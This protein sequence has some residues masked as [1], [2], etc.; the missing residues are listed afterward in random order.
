M[1]E[2]II[3]RRDFPIGRNGSA[4]F[5][6]DRVHFDEQGGDYASDQVGTRRHG[7]G[8][9]FIFRRGAD[10]A[11]RDA[12]R[13]QDPRSDLD[14]GLHRRNHGYMVYD[15]L[16]AIDEKGEIKPQMVKARGVGDDKLT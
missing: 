1:R 2:A 6:E 5:V 11:G 4:D 9:A 14:H 13:P 8:A 15:T 12:F 16:F 3:W 7:G 10:A